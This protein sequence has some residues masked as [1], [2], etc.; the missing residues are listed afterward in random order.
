MS[1]AEQVE[2][3]PQTEGRATCC[4]AVLGTGTIGLRHLDLL[5][6]IDGV[7]PLALPT[8]RERL[9]ELGQAGYAT[10]EG[11]EEAIRIGATLCVI[12]TDPKR[13]LEDALAAMDRGLDVLVEKPLATTARE[14]EQIVRYARSSRRQ[15]FVGCVLRFSESL[16]TLRERLPAVGR[17]H[18]VRIECQSYLPDWRPGHPYQA[19]YSARADEG[20]VLRDLIHE[21]DYAGWLFGWPATVR[22]TVRNL[23]RLGIEADEI[24]ELMWETPSGALLSVCLDYLSRP[25]RRSLRAAGEG[26]TIVW[27]GMSGTV[28]LQVEGE[29]VEDV[30]TSQT[31]EEMLLAQDL[32]FLRACGGQFG[33][34]PAAE[35]Q[36]LPVGL[37]LAT[38]DDGVMALA[39][40]DAARRASSSG[41]QDVV[42]YPA[43]L[44]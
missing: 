40:C 17:L 7:R 37:Q 13:H 33:V 25:S 44:R 30:R 29:P 11:L 32:A 36:D 21:F 19:S 43:G 38:G 2:P 16:N 12:A 6:Q 1:R 41:R 15:L 23:G 10:A 9:H 24:A 14:A 4:V 31:R 27:D 39:V 3:Q 28:T 18:A 8:R 35:A 22:A 26:G 42:E 20:G 34:R 5:G